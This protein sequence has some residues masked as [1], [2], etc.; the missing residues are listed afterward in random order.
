MTVALECP[1]ELDGHHVAAC[2][3]G[4]RRS[5]AVVLRHKRTNQDG[6]VLRVTFIHAEKR[7]IAVVDKLLLLVW[8]LSIRLGH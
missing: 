1:I 6:R 2:T 5:S 3:G 7:I 4:H 8:E